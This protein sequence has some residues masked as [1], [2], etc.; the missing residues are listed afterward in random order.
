M[1]NFI[2]ALGQKEEEEKEKIDVKKEGS[3]D[4]VN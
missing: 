1:L 2:L 4:L 3:G